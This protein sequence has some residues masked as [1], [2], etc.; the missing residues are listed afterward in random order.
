MQL[1]EEAAS[2]LLSDEFEGAGDL[3]PTISIN[4]AA[5]NGTMRR[6]TIFF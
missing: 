6:L 5:I 3:Q 2:P 1:G 4:P